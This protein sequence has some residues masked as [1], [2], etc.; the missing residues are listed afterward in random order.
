MVWT[1]GTGD[2]P[3]DA[4]AQKHYHSSGRRYCLL[5]DRHKSERS[6]RLGYDS[7]VLYPPLY[8]SVGEAGEVPW[9]STVLCCGPTDWFSQTGRQFYLQTRT[10]WPSKTTHMGGHPPIHT[11]RRT[12][13]YQY[14]RLSR[15]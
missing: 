10:Q 4:S 11:R 14:Q 5:S 1:S 13:C 8:A 7:V 6:C 15:L 12:E 2:A 3:S 9:S